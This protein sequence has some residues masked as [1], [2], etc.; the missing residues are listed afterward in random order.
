MTK[1]LLMLV[2]VVFLWMTGSQAHAAQVKKTKEAGFP[3]PA[4]VLVP[5]AIVDA[6]GN[7]IDDT[8]LLQLLVQANPTL[9]AA[10]TTY[11]DEIK[12]AIVSG[13]FQGGISV[14]G[15]SNLVI[16]VPND[17]H[18]STTDPNLIP[19]NPTN[20]PVSPN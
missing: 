16:T 11:F 2:S 6:N 10:I 3:D 15:K 14:S 13:N 8:T 17:L 19:E 18:I 9:G 5:T 4:T 7:V 1:K 20:P 12:S